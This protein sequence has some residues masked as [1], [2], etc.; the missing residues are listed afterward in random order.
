MKTAIC[1]CCFTIVAFCQ[2]KAQDKTQYFSR[3]FDAKVC[4]GCNTYEFS[5]N[6]TVSW[7]CTDGYKAKGTYK[8]YYNNTPYVE[9]YCF[10]ITWSNGRKEDKTCWA[11]YDDEKESYIVYISYD[12]F[13]SANCW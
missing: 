7:E 11:Y 1:I 3:P 10:R 13:W 9:R 8:F 5:S 4:Y 6:G 2:I 12:S